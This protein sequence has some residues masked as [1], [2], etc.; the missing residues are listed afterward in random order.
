MSEWIKDERENEG[1]KGRIKVWMSE[2]IVE[3]MNERIDG[4]I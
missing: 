4:W 1:M 2:W 3:W